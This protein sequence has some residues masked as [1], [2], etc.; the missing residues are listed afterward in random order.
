[1]EWKE[2]LKPFYS[3]LAAFMYL[4][5]LKLLSISLPFSLNSQS[6]FWDDYF[7]QNNKTEKFKTKALEIDESNTNYLILFIKKIN[8]QIF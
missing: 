3:G 1:M 6:L 7:D 4:D 8:F 5:Y 2:L